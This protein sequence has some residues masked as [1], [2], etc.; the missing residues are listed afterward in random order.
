MKERKTEI[1]L[2][3]KQKACAYTSAQIGETL[4]EKRKDDWQSGW[5]IMYRS[6]AAFQRYL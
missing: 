5:S 6:R 1:V 2:T 4:H 3:Q